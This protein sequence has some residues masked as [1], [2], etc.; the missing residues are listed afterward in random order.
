MTKERFTLFRAGGLKRYE[1]LIKFT[2]FVFPQKGA[3]YPPWQGMQYMYNMFSGSAKL[4]PLDN[5]RYPDMR[6]TPVRDILAA[7]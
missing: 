5:E 1:M 6:W 7:R 3:V 2:R 4:E